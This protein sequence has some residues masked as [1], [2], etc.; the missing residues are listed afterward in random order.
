MKEQGRQAARNE[1]FQGKEEAMELVLSNMEVQALRETLKAEISML[2]MEIAR[3]D[4]REMREG[5]KVKE[6][7]LESILEKLPPAVR[8]A[9]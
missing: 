5:L 1:R 9:A 3:T 8:S 6:E 7:L 4:N 2:L